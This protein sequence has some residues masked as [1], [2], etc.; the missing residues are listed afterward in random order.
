MKIRVLGSAAGGGFPQ[1][2]CGC[3][4]CAGVR[5]G[6]VNA[7]P[8]TQAQLAV[9][10]G[11]SWFL[12]GASP[13]LRAQIESA[14]ELHPRG[15]RDTP[16]AGVVLGNG[17]LDHV[18]GLYSLRE[19]QPLVVWA[20]ERVR[21]GLARNVISRTLER[22]AG[23]TTWRGLVLGEEQAL[24]ELALAAFPVRGK[25]PL[26][27][28]EDR[29]DED[30][31]ALRIRGGGKTLVVA[32]TVGGPSP[33]LEKLV[34]EADVLFFDGTF[35][36]SEELTG[37]GGRRAEEMAHWPVRESLPFLARAPGRTML[38]HINNTNPILDEDSPERAEVRGAGIEVAH[39]GLEIEL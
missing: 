28:P 37:L 21:A 33:V 35:W 10:D 19:S 27:L 20:T 8:R 31:V 24:G 17:D 22:F 1:W 12:L 7:R 25:P 18:L 9:G 36:T 29:S 39:D 14:P 38:I 26:H 2:N 32:P 23:Q 16:I 5:A 30:T 4:L 13:E 11:R 3:H 6:T 15:P 34:A